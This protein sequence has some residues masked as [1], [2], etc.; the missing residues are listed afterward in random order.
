MMLNELCMYINFYR[1]YLR[2][3]NQ[4]WAILWMILK[5]SCDVDNL[6]RSFSISQPGDIE[7][8]IIF[9]RFWTFLKFFVH[10]V[11]FGSFFGSFKFYSKFL[12]LLFFEFY[13][14]IKTNFSDSNFI[15][16]LIKFAMKSYDFL[17]FKFYSKL[18]QFL[19]F[20]GKS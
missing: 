2:F 15:V 4:C 9:N 16:S 10:W 19:N 14:K 17:N 12:Q 5:L 7:L 3:M 13:R 1:S 6:T 18:L 8:L 11:G 20:I